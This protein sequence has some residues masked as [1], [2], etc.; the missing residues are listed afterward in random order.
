[1]DGFFDHVAEDSHHGAR[2]GFGEPFISEALHEFEGVEVVVAGAGRG[3]REGAEGGEA[4]V[5]ERCIEGMA[6]GEG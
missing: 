1:M 5:D 3:G 2:L 4:V 6:S